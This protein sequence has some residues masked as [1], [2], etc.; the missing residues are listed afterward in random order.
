MVSEKKRRIVFAPI[1]SLPRRAVLHWAILFTYLGLSELA[2][3]SHAAWTPIKPANWISYNHSYKIGGG[4][5][6]FEQP[7]DRNC[8]G[9]CPRY[10]N[11]LYYKRNYTGNAW[12]DYMDLRMTSFS[13]EP[14]FDHLDS[15]YSSQTGAPSVPFWMPLLQ[16]AEQGPLTFYT[17]STE[18][19]P[20][21]AADQIR[22]FSSRSSMYNTPN[23]LGNNVTTVGVLLGQNDVIDFS[24]LLPSGHHS[25][26]ALVVEDPNADFDL[27][28]RCGAKPTETSFD[29]K[30]WYDGSQDF[31]HIDSCEN[32]TIYASVVSFSGAGPFKLYRKD[33]RSDNGHVAIRASLHWGPPS[34][35]PNVSS[36]ATALRQ[37]AKRIFS[38]SAGQ[39]FV[40]SI[41]LYRESCDTA[42]NCGGQGCNVCYK[43]IPSD[44]GD[45]STFNP[46][47]WAEL[48]GSSTDS[49]IGGNWNNG[50]I[51]N[52]FIDRAQDGFEASRILMHEL[53]HYFWH[54][55]DQY[56][57]SGGIRYFV[58]GH[59]VEGQE[60]RPFLNT[61]CNYTDHARDPDP[62]APAP[63][64]TSDYE[65]AVAN[66]YG[67]AW[68]AA[69]SGFSQDQYDFADFIRAA[70]FNNVTVH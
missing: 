32:Q 40:N 59:S 11:Y 16:G 56:Q 57:W 3:P 51:I 65:Q 31:V 8:S 58:C 21:F 44:C 12:T 24:F 61:F 22:V 10:S 69:V 37:G 4:S 53:G 13:T 46:Y 17:D 41:D 34:N 5:G 33:H 42:S 38:A 67:I 30:S 68:D 1:A 18:T 27:Y 29:W 7:D 70:S 60:R 19:Y 63:T 39:I 52:S 35:D 9:T 50:V 6:V 64:M 23:S 28:V 14:G 20:G 48:L 36:V 25:A 43:D 26:L 49:C 54:L 15:Q 45:A 47:P 2:S 62:G 66:G 55:S